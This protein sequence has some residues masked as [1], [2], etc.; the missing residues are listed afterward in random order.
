MR[1]DDGVCVEVE[2]LIGFELTEPFSVEFESCPASGEA[3]HKDVDVDLNGFFVFDVFV[4]QFDHLVIHDTKGLNFSTVIGQ[5]G[6]KPGQGRNGFD[7]CCLIDRTCP[8]SCLASFWQE[9]VDRDFIGFCQHQVECL[10][11]L[12]SPRGT[13]C[14]CRCHHL[15]N[16][17]IHWLLA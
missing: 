11:C 7:S 13:E 4:D 16:R 6:M 9:N 3:G 1:E 10:P 14:I 12:G 17:A 15:P 8:R 5:Q 2:G